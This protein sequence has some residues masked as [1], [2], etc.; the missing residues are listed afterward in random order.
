[1]HCHNSQAMSN[2]VD[3]QIELNRI[4]GKFEKSWR[5]D[6][7]RAF[8][9]LT[10]NNSKLPFELALIALIPREIELRI[11]DEDESCV[12]DDYELFDKNWINDLIEKAIES[13]GIQQGL[14]TQ[15][16]QSPAAPSKREAETVDF[17]KNQSAASG[18]REDQTDEGFADYK[19]IKEIARGGMGVVYQARDKRLNRIVALKMI[20]SG[21]FAH[22]EEIERFKSEAEAAAKL[23]HPG[24][25]P[26]Y[27]IGDH[28]GNPYFTMGFI[29]GEN[30][31]GIT[32]DGPLEP[33]QAARIVVD[34][35][36]AV[37]YAHQKGV[38]HRDL[39]PAN[40]LM[41]A[42]G[43][44]KVTDFGLAK[45]MGTNSELTGTGQILGTPG[46]MPPE[47]AAG[48]TNQV[49]ERADVY[50]V[51]AIL[52]YLL[53]NR[54]PFQASRPLDTLLQV[55]ESEPVAPRTL[56][57]KIPKDLE[58]I[59]L[60]CLR[61]EPAKRYSS[62]DELANDL[63]RWLRNEPIVA[64]RFGTV[65]KAK[66]WCKRK[67]VH[68]GS[69]ATIA[70]I[71]AV[72]ITAVI[73]TRKAAEQNR[74]NAEA[75]QIVKR[76]ATSDTSQIESIIGD[77]SGFRD[78]AEDD[79]RE[80]YR[81]SKE[82]SNAKLHAALAILKVKDD[83]SVVPF[84]KNRMLAVTPQQ[85]AHVSDL[86]E[87]EKM[88]L[89][90]HYWKVA[91]N[92]E[93]MESSRFQAACALANYDP[94]NQSWEQPE[95]CSF[96]A[97]YLVQVPLSELLPWR[98][99]LHPVKENLAG[100]LTIIAND[101]DRGEVE[102]N[103]AT[104][105]LIA[106]VHNDVQAL[107]NMLVDSTEQQ[108]IPIYNSLSRHRERAVDLA[109]LEI[110]MPI[111]PDLSE[112]ERERLARRQ[113]NAAVL[114]LKQ[115]AADRVW[116][117]LAH[118]PDPIVRSH[119]IH[120]MFPRKCKA[121]PIIKRF[122][123]ETDVTI[124]R[125]LLLCL[126]EFD[127][128]EGE[129]E[130]LADLLT[131]VYV[132]ERDAGLHSAAEW[133][134]RK[135]EMT[136][137][138]LPVGNVTL[139]EKEQ[140]QI[141]HLDAEIKD[142]E[143]NVAESMARWE[144]ELS[145]KPVSLGNLEDESL[146]HV[147]FD[148]RSTSGSGSDG[149]RK[150]SVAFSGSGEPDSLPGVFGDAAFLNGDGQHF[151]CDETISFTRDQPFSLSC[152]FYLPSN[153]L[154]DRRRV[155][156]SKYDT[157]QEKGISISVHGNVASC[158][159]SNHYPSNWIHV[160]SKLQNI[161]GRWCHLVVSYDGSV[162]A[163][164]LQIFQ[165]GRPLPATT[166]ADSL[167]ESIQN[168]SPALIG[169]RDN[170]YA[171]EGGLD[172]LLIFQRQLSKT[173]IEQL[174][175]KGVQAIVSI[176][177]EQ[178]TF[179]QSA[180]LDSIEKQPSFHHLQAKLNEAQHSLRDLFNQRW[181]VN[182]QGQTFAILNAG[183]FTMGS[184][185]MDNGSGELVDGSH[186]CRI[187]RCF[188]IAT[189]EVT[190]EHWDAFYKETKVWDPEGKRVQSIAKGNDA[191]MVGMNWYQATQYCNWLSKKDGIPEEQWCY[192]K[193]E[194]DE[195]G[196]GMKA[197]DNFWELT[198]Y[199]LPTEA[200]WEYACRAGTTSRRFYGSAEKLLPKYA[201]FQTNTPDI[202]M[203]P[204]GILKPND[205]GLFDIYGN[206]NEFCYGFLGDFDYFQVEGQNVV[207]DHPPTNAVFDHHTL[208]ER[209][210]AIG[211]PSPLVTSDARGGHSPSIHSPAA[212]LRVV[213]TYP[214]PQ[215]KND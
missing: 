19:I 208:V 91:E 188:A 67:P 186:R 142:L 166:K 8:E 112:P 147:P 189:T 87:S 78:Y 159:W 209:G 11:R 198:G 104:D 181:Y 68:A 103:F 145:A 89:I 177:A 3:R 168:S 101:S 160:E 39:K 190:K 2:E 153:V 96:V 30:L 81:V 56:D 6:R 162:Q 45:Q 22:G 66:L 174:Y 175:L 212:G 180:L 21:Q 150:N 165:D 43:N 42:G 70:L 1:M 7:K 154:L 128:D 151:V 72:S 99:A 206:T 59:C 107:F 106:Y 47:Q 54:P 15:G 196:P 17:S 132:S 97:N 57:P 203:K 79:L 131:N 205:F 139:T 52:Y 149:A 77:L 5:R 61:K 122:E 215:N 90:P 201:W 170:S 202:K 93:E 144:S 130:L 12:A 69:L 109:K 40:V 84:L 152:W 116:P 49:D 100:P 171:F 194:R 86:L 136:I 10:Y 129:K 28:D 146:L 157:E 210:G 62:A 50:A 124:K 138:Q 126:G 156:F 92:Q 187:D 34:V 74:K 211:H 158:E 182:N 26:I 46:Y 214:I 23:D 95:F 38:I 27:E 167:T 55:L 195:H 105:T 110:E 184:E 4:V 207:H 118:R 108:Y 114:L 155:L 178:R 200:E 18:Q 161:A 179:A 137:P 133:L 98:V 33:E 64:R 31:Q 102:R 197:K 24:I 75:T 13:R 192:E 163:K 141:E 115:N 36:K 134:L 58:T 117:I 73:W 135:F 9:F 14:P 176:S 120:S 140:Q 44:P 125:A 121:E 20:R 204:V 60:K 80:T 83:K 164:G 94:E 53:V 85:F 191:P 173:E 172:D 63:E 16:L 76:L 82:D 199:R 213:R 127:L 35:A 111:G 32:A 71:L 65:E 25:V 169:R 143:L 88:A 123:Q 185:S 41:D 48:N 29:E 183:E 193:N 113:A 148:S 51:G 119:L 37:A